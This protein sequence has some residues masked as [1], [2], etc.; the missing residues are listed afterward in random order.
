MTRRGL[1]LPVHQSN[2]LGHHNHHH[3]SHKTCHSAEASFQ[4]TCCESQQGSGS[5]EISDETTERSAVSTTQPSSSVTVSHLNSTNTNKYDDDN[6]YLGHSHAEK[7]CRNHPPR[8]FTERRPSCG[9]T[10][11]PRSASRWK[12]AAIL[13][14]PPRS[15]PSSRSSISRR[16]GGFPSPSW[17]RKRFISLHPQD[18]LSWV[19]SKRLLYAARNKAKRRKRDEVLPIWRGMSGIPPN[20]LVKKRRFI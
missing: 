20:N 11:R 19:R 9:G 8:L 13:S 3:H 12:G 18:R 15:N 7:S 4:L 6:V 5:T 1:L 10:S 16:R 14:A 17:S 2:L